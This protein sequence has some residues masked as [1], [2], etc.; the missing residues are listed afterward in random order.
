M[1][2]DPGLRQAIQAVNTADDVAQLAG[3]LGHEL[4]ARRWEGS[5][6]PSKTF[7]VNPTDADPRADRPHPGGSLLDNFS[8]EWTHPLRGKPWATAFSQAPTS[9]ATL[10]SV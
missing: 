3:T 2:D 5:R 6:S 10:I 1:Q 7:P 9:S 8:G 4:L